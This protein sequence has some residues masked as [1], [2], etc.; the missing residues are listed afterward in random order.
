M[1]TLLNPPQ[2]D[3][4]K[5]NL[6]K[7]NNDVYEFLTGLFLMN[8][9]VLNNANFATLGM[10]GQSVITTDTETS[11]EWKI[12]GSANAAFELNSESYPA[13][14]II[15]SA[16]PYY[17]HVVVS[18]HNGDSFYLYQRQDDT[19]RKYQ[20]SRLTYGLIIKNNQSKAVKVRGDIYS[21]YDTDES[22]V[23]GKPKLLQPGMNVISNTV[24]T[25]SLSGK[26]VGA[27]PY[28]EFRLSFIDLIDGT[29]DLEIYQ[30]KCEFGMARTMLEQ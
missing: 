22:L 2:P 4:S 6:Y 11:D 5:E 9:S 24:L 14:S 10:H 12:V 20:K 21:Y 23:S 8:P 30:I 13:N 17:L 7:F 3:P 28:T 1:T 26:T 15:Q 29:A 16:S 25:E 18:S 19:V 27:N